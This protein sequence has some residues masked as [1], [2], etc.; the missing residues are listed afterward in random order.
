MNSKLDGNWQESEE[1]KINQKKFWDNYPKIIVKHH[2]K[3]KH[4][5]SHM[6]GVINAKI[7]CN[8]LKNYMS[9][10]N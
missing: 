3:H 9:D 4:H 5:Q 8:F 10:F 6:H 2:Q 7:G 1:N